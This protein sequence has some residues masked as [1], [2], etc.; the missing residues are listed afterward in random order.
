MP[1]TNTGDQDILISYGDDI[2]DKSINRRF[3]GIVPVGIYEG[4]ELTK[5]GSNQI[6]VAPGLVHIGDGRGERVK[7]RVQSSVSL[8]SVT[9]SSNF[10]AIQWEY[11]ADESWFARID[12][13]GAVSNHMVLL[14]KA[15]FDNND[16]IDDID[17]RNRGIITYKKG[18]EVREQFKTHGAR[19]VDP[20]EVDVDSFSVGLEGRAF[21]VRTDQLNSNMTVNL[22]TGTD[23]QHGREVEVSDIGG[24]ASSNNISISAGAN[25]SVMGGGS[26][27]IT[28][29]YGSKSFRY[30]KGVSEW[31]NI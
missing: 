7:I 3:E 18:L 2:T 27:S 16:N 12:S 25:E 11:R 24:N 5:T 19:I 21:G 10:I 22:P 29:D 23:L 28:T 14:G 20:I 30:Y 8:S 4:L 9:P 31:V 17:F 6:D 15:L 1:Y 26:V 13:F